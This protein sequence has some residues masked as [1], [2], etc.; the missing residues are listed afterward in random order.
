MTMEFYSKDYDFQQWSPPNNIEYPAIVLY[1]DSWD[2]FHYQTFYHMR[3]FYSAT[4]SEKIG[5]LKILHKG[6]KN[7]K[8]TRN[9]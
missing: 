1:K 5:Y 8:I 9:V 7:H 4:K 6:R 3:F 2:D